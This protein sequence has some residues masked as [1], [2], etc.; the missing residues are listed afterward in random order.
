M[1]NKLFAALLLLVA[2]PALATNLPTLENDTAADC[3]LTGTGVCAVATNGAGTVSFNLSSSGASGLTYNFQGTSD[4]TH[5]FAVAYADPTGSP[6]VTFANST[7]SATSGQ[8]IVAA[9]GLQKIR[10]NLTAYSAGTLTIHG[11][12]GSGSSITYVVGGSVGS[13]G[14][15]TCSACALETGGNLAAI[16]NDADTLAGAVSGSLFQVNVSK[17]NATTID[18]NSGNKSAGTQRV[19]I[20]TDQPNLTSAL[21]VAESTLDG[22]LSS[23]KLNTRNY[24]STGNADTQPHVCGS[25]KYVHITSATDTQIVAAS[26]STTIYVCDF[27]FSVGAVATNFY[28]EKATTGTCATLTQLG[29]LHNGQI[30]MTAKASNAFYRGLNTGSSAQLCVNTSAAGPLD[31]GVFYDQY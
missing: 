30:G 2:T 27:E 23:S 18:T 12:A 10:L 31:I 24:F 22:A 3:T 4:G 7:L 16:K 21:N 6:P 19:V 26:G 15:F 25:Y 1:R 5:W 29:I 11:E 13:S 17:L 28:L 14:T 9:G 8:W 20:A